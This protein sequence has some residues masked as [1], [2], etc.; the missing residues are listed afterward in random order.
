MFR[1]NIFVAL[2]LAWI[3]G[4]SAPRTTERQVQAP[5]APSTVLKSHPFSGT[6]LLVAEYQRGF[7]TRHYYPLWDPSSNVVLEAL[8]QVTNYLQHASNEPLSHSAYPKE[9]PGVQD[10]LAKT[11]CQAI[12]VTWIGRKGI[13]LN[14][15]PAEG[16][17]HERWRED[18]IKVHDGGPRYWSVIYF[19]GE[20]KFANLHID[21]G[22]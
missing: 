8:S 10:R 13:L 17:W 9:L 4:C 19:V 22:F 14:C 5:A 16:Y 18:F 7:L 2:T 1:P 6:V 11:V 20:R 3:V 15:F 12:G 21:L